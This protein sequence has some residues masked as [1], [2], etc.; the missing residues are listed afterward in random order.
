MLKKLINITIHNNSML[1][2]VLREQEKID[3]M[4]PHQE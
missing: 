3:L 4:L 2:E 1:A